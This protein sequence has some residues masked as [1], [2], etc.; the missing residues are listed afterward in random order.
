MGIVLLPTCCD[1]R[2]VLRVFIVLNI[3]EALFLL[4]RIIWFCISPP[5]VQAECK[6]SNIA[7]EIANRIAYGGTILIVLVPLTCNF[8]TIQL[9][10]VYE[11][12]KILE[13]LK[14][15]AYQ[16]WHDSWDE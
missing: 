4:G 14:A 1:E 2:I 6:Q 15:H 12:N 10:G 7:F 8:L 5:K 13:H 11:A 16:S 9:V 3:T